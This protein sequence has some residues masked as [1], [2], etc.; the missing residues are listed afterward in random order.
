MVHYSSTQR[1]DYGY[2]DVIDINVHPTAV[3]EELKYGDTTGTYAWIK[4]DHCQFI[5][6]DTYLSPIRDATNSTAQCAADMARF[7]SYN[8]PLG[9]NVVPVINPDVVPS[10]ISREV[11]AVNSLCTSTCITTDDGVPTAGFCRQASGTDGEVICAPTSRLHS[12]AWANPQ[13]SNVPFDSN[14]V[15]GARAGEFIEW[16]WDQETATI[17]G[18]DVWLMASPAAAAA[19]D[20]AGATEVVPAS[21]Q[22]TVDPTS[23]RVDP[24]RNRYQIPSSTPTAAVLVFEGQYCAGGHLTTSLDRYLGADSTIADCDANCRATSG[25]HFYSYTASSN[26][27][28]LLFA[29]CSSGLQYGNGGSG[30]QTMELPGTAQVLHFACAVGT[31]CAAGQV[32]EVIVGPD[33]TVPDP[34]SDE[35]VCERDYTLCS[36]QSQ[37]TETE[38]EFET[39]V[40]V[41]FGDLRAATSLRMYGE[42][43]DPK[44]HK[45]D[46]RCNLTPNPCAKAPTLDLLI[47]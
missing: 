16:R 47:C 5:E 17:D 36:D 24:G 20:F 3:P 4:V 41:P 25:C 6:P 40:N 27:D 26:G 18:H 8:K 33:P 7:D 32:V 45:P 19:C 12:I 14:T 28:C 37:Q 13:I 21:Q 43:S 10:S 46:R 39:G 2:A 1:T 29:Q 30:T 23:G 44:S 22:A 15:T 31:H 38:T 42:V 34:D 11:E 9:I 35:G